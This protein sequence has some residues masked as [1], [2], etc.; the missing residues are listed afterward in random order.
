MTNA[1]L[2]DKYYEAI[3]RG[4]STALES[5]ISPGFVLNWQGSQRIPWAGVWQGA[6]GVQKFMSVL[7]QHLEV[8]EIVRL[9]TFEDAEVTVSVLKGRWR[10]KA[11]GVEISALAGNLFTFAD[12]RINSYTVMNNS[13][14]F[15]EEFAQNV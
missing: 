11:S 3:K 2:L 7:G 5:C 15:A 4:D 13:A 10:M 14:A 12:G 8:L 9:H 1:Q 6:E